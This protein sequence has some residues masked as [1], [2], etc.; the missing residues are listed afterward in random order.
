MIVHKHVKYYDRLLTVQ[1]YCHI[2]DAYYSKQMW[3][4]F[5]SGKCISLSDNCKLTVDH[6]LYEEK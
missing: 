4:A 2:A 6:W 3:E 1:I 5:L